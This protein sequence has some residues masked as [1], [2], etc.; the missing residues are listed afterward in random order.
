[1][2]ERPILFSAPMVRALLA[3]R[4]TQTRRVVKFPTKGEYVRPDMGGWTA[5]TIGGDGSRDRHGREVPVQACV[6]NQTTGTTVACPYGVLGDRLWVKE[7]WQLHERFTDVGRVVY[8]ASAN[9]AWSEAH[10]DFPIDT[11]G[12]L[13]ARP[14]QEGWRSPLH[15]PRR[16][17][18]L[19]LTI[20]AVRAE[21]LQDIT[22]IDAE[23]EGVQDP[24][25]VPIL[26]AFW[27]SRDG[28]ARLWEHINGPGSWASNPWVWVVTFQVEPRR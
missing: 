19:D 24:S 16:L 15:M 10:I 21:R 2:K 22:E 14:F 7:T 17:S 25:L 27:S 1:M 23:A 6:W 11:V 20:T 12:D 5:C 4:K 28:Y 8:A 18:R 3:G 9:G 26:G 13:T